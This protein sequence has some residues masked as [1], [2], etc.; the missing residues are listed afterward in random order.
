M[1]MK[2]NTSRARRAFAIMCVAITTYQD[3]IPAC[4][5]KGWFLVKP[6]PGS[7]AQDCETLRSFV[8]K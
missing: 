5:S 8:R 6:Y 3:L 2:R 1:R 7:R 4:G